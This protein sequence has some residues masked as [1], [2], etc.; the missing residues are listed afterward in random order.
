MEPDRLISATA[1][2][3]PL[4]AESD[5]AVRRAIDSIKSA[6]VDALVGPMS[7]LITGAVD[8][9]FRA[10]RFAYEAAASTGGVVMQATVSNA[11]P[12]PRRG[13]PEATLP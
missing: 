3:Y 11:C 7:T 2:V 10:L 13:S 4:Q 9:V 1:A 12:S 6:D 5:V 8:E